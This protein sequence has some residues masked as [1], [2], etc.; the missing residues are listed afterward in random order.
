MSLCCYKDMFKVKIWDK[1]SKVI[2][3]GELNEGKKVK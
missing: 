2:K 1:E 3:V